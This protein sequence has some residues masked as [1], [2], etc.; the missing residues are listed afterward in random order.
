MANNNERVALEKPQAPDLGDEELSWIIVEEVIF[1]DRAPWP[2][3][4]DGFGPSLH[5]VDVSVHGCEPGNWQAA[6]PSLGNGYAG[7]QPPTITSQP[8]PASLTSPAGATLS[9]SVAA[10]GTAPFRYQWLFDGDTIDGEVGETLSL[11]NVQ[12]E[13]SGVYS[14]LVL[15]SAGSALSDPVSLFVTTPPRITQQP[16]NVTI[17]PGVNALFVVNAFGN[18]VLNYQWR[19]NGNDIPGA[20][21]ASYT[22]SNAA[23]DDDGLYTVV[24]TDINGSV[25]STAARLKVLIAPEIIMNLVS[26]SVLAGGT[27]TFSIQTTGTLPI[28]YR[29]RRGNTT[30]GNFLLDSHLAFLTLTN[31]E[32]SDAGSYR[33]VLTN[34]A[35]IPPGL[36]SPPATLTILTDADEDGMDDAWE[37]E[38][39]LDPNSSADSGLDGDG[40]GLT[41]KQEYDA[42]TDPKDANSFLKIEALDAD[43]ISTA[44][45][46]IRFLAAPNRTYTIQSKD[47]L[48]TAP[49]SRVADVAAAG[50]NRVVEV[51]DQ[52]SVGITR[53]YYRLTTPRVP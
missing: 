46:R 7:G 43:F 20:S 39:Q 10:N 42:G 8:S 4:A 50:T 13:H 29:W 45:V 18:G 36:L 12:P 6:S 15:N 30:V 53:R 41:N 19:F 31:L 51:L 26:Q 44:A 24:V 5:R 35:S 48:T 11:Q 16:T 21:S 3:A 33:V 27:V 28:G 49:W 38:H 1:A 34:E 9:Y 17:R 2:L 37:S 32:A 25:V 40:D 23:A 14:V 47:A 22:V 52:P